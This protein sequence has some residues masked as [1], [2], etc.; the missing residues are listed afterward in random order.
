[1]DIRF[2][3]WDESQKYMA[4]QGTA[5]IETLQSFI[6]HFGDKELMQSTNIFDKNEKEIFEGDYLKYSNEYGRLHYYKV[7][8]VKGGLVINTHSDDVN[9][10]TNFYSAC[11]DMQTMQWIKQCE[12]IGNIY[13]NQY[14]YKNINSF[15]IKITGKCENI[16]EDK[17]LIT[18][19]NYYIALKD[20]KNI[21]LTN[22]IIN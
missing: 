12:V 6:H 4:Y 13:E 1:M 22:N 15:V 17:R 3:A 9:K 10:D 11:A 8:R 19:N 16:F 21:K 18:A 5:D 2:R 20:S 7:R 14:N